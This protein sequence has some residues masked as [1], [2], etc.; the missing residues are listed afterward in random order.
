M[1]MESLLQAAG[2]NVYIDWRDGS[3]PTSSSRE[4]AS[5]IKDR[6]KAAVY[7]L[8]LATPNSVVSR[9]CPWEIGYADG[10]KP[11]DN[12]FVIPTSD[13]DGN[14]YGNEYLQLY[15]QIDFSKADELA[16]WMPGQDTGGVRVRA[17]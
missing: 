2:W 16:A 13:R 11:I 12:L 8:F 3:M 4:T 5:K 6:I 10:V 15:R 14:H 7:F 17:L 1:G 9:W